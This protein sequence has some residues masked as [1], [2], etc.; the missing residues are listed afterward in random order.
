[1]SSGLS[2]NSRARGMTTSSDGPNRAPR[3]RGAIVALDYG[4]KRSGIAACDALHLAA[5]PVAVVQTQDRE[6]LLEAVVEAVDE[7]NATT[8]VVGLPLHLAGHD[9]ARARGVRDLCEELRRRL[10]HVDV[11]PWDER[12]TTKEAV[13]LLADVGVRGKKR[14]ERVDA[15]AA[16][17][18][19]RSYLTH[20]EASR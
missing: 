15:V 20:L 1:M 2:T 9:S 19:L 17:L 14:K 4:D 18:I 13:S 6:E 11:V 7:R 3:R 16:V 5:V 8:L 10:P 12:L